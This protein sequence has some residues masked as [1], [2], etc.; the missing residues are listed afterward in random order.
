RRLHTRS[1]RD[2]SSDVCSSDLVGKRGFFG[3]FPQIGV[4]TGMLFASAVLALMN[5]IAPGEAFLEWGWRVP[6]LLSIV[7]VI[8][9]LFVRSSRSEERRAGKGGLVWWWLGYT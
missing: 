4:P 8:V 7:L 5:W 3:A 1:K 6:F 9:G 2:W